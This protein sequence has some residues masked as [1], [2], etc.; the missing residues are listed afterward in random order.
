[1]PMFGLADPSPFCMK[2]MALLKMSGI[3]HECVPGDPRQ[4]PKGKIPWASDDGEI[5]ADSTFIRLH[6]EREHGIDF[7]P[8]VSVHDRA[9]GWAFEKMCEEHLYFCILFDRWMI[10]ANFDKGP[11]R[12]FD[13]IP[14]LMRPMVLAMVRRD[15]RHTLKGQGIG[16]HG[17]EEIVELARHDFDAL[18]NFLGEKTYFLGDRLTG[19]DAVVHSFL[20]GAD[21]AFFDGPIRQ[22]VRAH[23][24]LIAYIDRVNAIWWPG[25]TDKEV[26]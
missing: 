2:A 10:D 25:P 23:D 11:R 6:L 3:E 26:A 4:A 16:R 8:G 17:H 12:F 7:F 5:I 20:A 21:A 1:M 14:A 15:I 22:A 18:A 19:T 13:Q 9:I 24:N